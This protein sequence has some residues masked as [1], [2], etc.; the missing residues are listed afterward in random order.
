M[1]MP[2]VCVLL[3]VV[4]WAGVTADGSELTPKEARGKQIYTSGISSS[5]EAITAHMGLGGFPLPASAMPCASCHGPDGRG[6]PGEIF[7]GGGLHSEG[8]L[9]G[10]GNIQIDLQDTLL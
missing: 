6:R 7:Q 4:G 5:G 10:F 3:L 9:A 1:R 2:H 8:A